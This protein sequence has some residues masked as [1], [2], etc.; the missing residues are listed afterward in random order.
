MGFDELYSQT[1]EGGQKKPLEM[2]DLSKGP[3]NRTNFGV[4]YA[5][6]GYR[7][8]DV[9]CGNGD[10]LFN[11]S[12]KYKELHGIDVSSAR[13]VQARENLTR[14]K[15]TVIQCEFDRGTEYQGAFFDTVVCLD[16]IEH[17]LDVRSAFEEFARILKPG[18]VLVIT[19]PNIARLNYRLALLAGRFPGTAFG[20]EGLDTRENERLIDAGHIHYFTFRSLRLLA[21]EVDLELVVKRGIGSRPA[22]YNLWP[23]FLSGSVATVFLRK[24]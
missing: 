11:L 4:L 21:E 16:V 5:P 7:V 1:Y 2:I 6:G 13:V 24:S 10:L 18:G 15:A 23:E 8:L 22:L 20:N 17:I 12:G 14:F 19:T 3:V 9:G